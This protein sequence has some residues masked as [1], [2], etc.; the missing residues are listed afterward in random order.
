MSEPARRASEIEAASNLYIIHPL[1]AWIVPYCAR[2]GITPNQVSLAGMGCGIAAGAAYHFYPHTACV[3]LGFALMIAWH[4]LDGADGQLAR[5]T[6]TFS[7][8]GK[9]IDGICDYVTYTAV[10]VGLALT[11]AAVHG[12]WVWWLVVLSGLCHAAQSAAYELQRQYFNVYGLGRTSSALPDL[13]APAP[14]GAA[15][16][17]HNIYTRAQLLIGRDAAAFHATLQSD[18]ATRARYRKTFAPVIRRWSLLSANTR[19]IA[20]FLCALAGAPLLYFLFEIFILSAALWALL[21][22]QRRRYAAFNAVLA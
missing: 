10:Y 7:E 19:T 1:S 12:G 20:I 2:A 3:F 5:L 18:E 21:A 4:V 11:L 8:L 14:S 17:L 6:S 9:I 22:D 15:G 16:V 13:N